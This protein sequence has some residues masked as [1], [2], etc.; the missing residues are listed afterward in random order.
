MTSYVLAPPKVPLEV[1]AV[2]GE[3]DVRGLD[4]GRHGAALGDAELVYG[5]DR[6]RCDEPGAVGVKHYVRDGFSAGD[7]GHAGR[8][9]VSCADLH[10]TQMLGDRH[11]RA[12]MGVCAMEHR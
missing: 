4:D 7:A 1:S 9:L 3:D 12:D 2:D 8:D 5:F 11:D 6:D 10:G